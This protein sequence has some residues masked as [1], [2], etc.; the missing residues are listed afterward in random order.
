MLSRIWERL[1]FGAPPAHPRYADD[2]PVAVSV[3]GQAP[4]S[5][6]G[7][8]EG[9]ASAP[10]TAELVEQVK[11]ERDALAQRL[12]RLEQTLADP[13]KGQNAILYYR[14]RTIWNVCHHDLTMLAR[15]FREK[16]EGRAA[17]TANEAANQ[18]RIVLAGRLR[19]ASAQEK[20]LRERVQRIR[21]DLYERDKP[22]R[23]GEKSALTRELEELE[24]R[25]DKARKR[26]AALRHEA[27]VTPPMMP[28]TALTLA[29]RRAINTLLIA[30]AQH[31]YLLFRD[32]QISEMALR[33]ARKPVDE[34]YFGLST[35]CLKLG[36]KTRELIALAKSEENRHELVR[37]RAQ[38]LNGRLRYASD[39]SAIPLRDS[40]KEIPTR[41]AASDEVFT[42]LGELVPVN[43]LALDYWDLS[44]ALVS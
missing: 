21:H 12:H 26:I 34:V 29:T 1:P 35:E 23:V 37:R 24:P 4:E 33:A 40:V 16:Y 41:I 30:L 13:D 18:E 2:G 19:E 31:Y 22:F 25:L 32:E 3:G 11:A 43:V 28:R 7:A 8:S 14:L 38:Y 20:A 17:T 6:P 9:K 42:N 39:T 36:Q 5:P 15:Q 10:A 27:A 44:R